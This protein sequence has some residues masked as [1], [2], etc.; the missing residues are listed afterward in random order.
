M[1][2]L[3]VVFGEIDQFDVFVGCCVKLDW[4]VDRL[5]VLGAREAGS[6]NVFCAVGASGC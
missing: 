6:N 1:L 2:Q 4:F 5:D 3:V